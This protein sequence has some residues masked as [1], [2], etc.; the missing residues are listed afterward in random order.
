MSGRNKCYVV[1]AAYLFG[2]LRRSVRMYVLVLCLSFCLFWNLISVFSSFFSKEQFSSFLPPVQPFY[3]PGWVVVAISTHSLDSRNA[4]TSSSS[5]L[6]VISIWLD[7]AY[8]SHLF[9][10]LRVGTVAV[11]GGKSNLQDLLLF[12]EE[13]KRNSFRTFIIHFTQS[14]CH[15]GICTDLCIKLGRLITTYGMC[16]LYHVRE[17]DEDGCQGQQ[18]KGHETASIYPLHPSQ[19]TDA[20]SISVL[21][22]NPS[23]VG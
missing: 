13:K 14:L 11:A 3:S 15:S 4:Q 2:F 18:V 6:S 12:W 17:R 5:V 23:L 10:M 7:T 22:G 8:L 1:Y 19:P 16:T 21:T 20:Q 9:S